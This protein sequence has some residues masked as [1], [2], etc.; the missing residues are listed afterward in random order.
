MDGV[1][2]PSTPISKD[3]GAKASPLFQPILTK[4]F[5]NMVFVFVHWSWEHSQHNKTIGNA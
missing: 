3:S 1:T 5:E 4:L 2:D